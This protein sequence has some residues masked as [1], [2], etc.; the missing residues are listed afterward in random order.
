MFWSRSVACEILVHWP[1]SEPGPWAVRAQSPNLDPQVVPEFDICF[2]SEV[3]HLQKKKFFLPHHAV[4]GILVP[5]LGTEPG[6]PAA[7]A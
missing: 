5:Q 2:F 4:C 6:P 1:G 3:Q 7:E